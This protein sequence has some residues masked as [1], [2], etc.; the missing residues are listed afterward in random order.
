MEYDKITAD[1]VR[2]PEIGRMYLDASPFVTTLAHHAYRQFADQ[3]ERQY[4][5]M[6]MVDRIK[7]EFQD[8]DPYTDWRDMVADVTVNRRLKVYRT[9]VDG[10]QD[11]PLLRRDEN[12]MFRAVHDY[13]GHHGAGHGSPV[14]FTRHGEEAAWVRHSRMFTGLARRAMT[15]ETR[16]QNSAFIWINGGR[17]FPQQKAVLLPDWVSD[18][19][20]RWSS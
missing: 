7:V 12:N 18:V 15:T 11:H 6:T 16:G 4:R 19:P 10:T 14:S 5:R 17:V 3:V 13:Y 1:P 2:G 8:D 9:P 20:E